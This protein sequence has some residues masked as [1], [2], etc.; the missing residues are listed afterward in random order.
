[1]GPLLKRRQRPE[2][3]QQISPQR[4]KV[5]ED[6]RIVDL[7]PEGLHDRSQAIHCLEPVQYRIRPEGYGVRVVLRFAFR[8]FESAGSLDLHDPLAKMVHLA[9]TPLHTVPYGTDSVFDKSQ[10]INCLATI[11]E[12]LRDKPRS[13]ARAPASPR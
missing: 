10:A 13:H 9:A 12:S 6:R 5:H 2:R 7:V 3:R 4:H 8:S 11:I 1:M